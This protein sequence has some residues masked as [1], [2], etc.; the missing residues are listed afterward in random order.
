MLGRRLR[1]GRGAQDFFA[2][3]ACVSRA[4]HQTGKRADGRGGTREARVFQEIPPSA[5][6]PCS[7][8]S[9]R[10]AVLQYAVVEPASPERIPIGAIE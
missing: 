2:N 7:G 6:L 5:G 3:G 9:L 10:H 8:R 4:R 1:L